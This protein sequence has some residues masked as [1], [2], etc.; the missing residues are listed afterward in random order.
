MSFSIEWDHCYRDRKQLSI[1]PWTDLVS[2]VM[3]YAKPGSANHRVLELG[4]GAGANIPFFEWL[5]V[6]YFAIEGSSTIVYQLHER[7]P[8]LQEKIVAGDFTKVIPFAGPFDLVVDRSSLTHNK[9]AD[10]K[11]ALSLVGS[12]LKLGGKFIGIDWFSTE[13][14][15]F[16]LGEMAEDP[17]TKRNIPSGQF[18]DVGTVH[19]SSRPHLEELFTEFVLETLDHK[20]IRHDVPQ[21]R[22]HQVYASWN[23]VA[24]KK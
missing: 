3:R 24:K 5:G 9:T 8:H 7:F 1:W 16:H 19:F 14:A 10:I 12:R 13:H 2:H 21:D 20:T 22:D 18:A 4:C 17:F 11:K 6:E 15:D 23:F